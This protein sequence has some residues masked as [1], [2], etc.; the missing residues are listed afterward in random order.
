MKENAQSAIRVQVPRI[1]P[2]GPINIQELRESLRGVH[3]GRSFWME[4]Q[5]GEIPLSDEEMRLLLAIP[6][7]RGW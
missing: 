6:P 4:Y 7:E 3:L 5:N 1:F 2:G